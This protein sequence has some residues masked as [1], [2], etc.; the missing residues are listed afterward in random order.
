MYE[1]VSVCMRMYLYVSYVSVC[2]V[3]I[4]MYLGF[5]CMYGLD[6]H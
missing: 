2:I 1:Y 3:C 6:F 5:I 4:S